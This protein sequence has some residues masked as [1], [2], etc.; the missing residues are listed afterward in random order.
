M[1]FKN[2]EI[3]M[4][5]K[6]SK[7]IKEAIQV[8]EKYMKN[9]AIIDVS[10]T[11]LEFIQELFKINNATFILCSTNRN[12]INAAE[13]R[14]EG[15]KILPRFNKPRSR[16]YEKSIMF[17]FDFTEEELKQNEIKKLY[18][19]SFNFKTYGISLLD[20]CLIKFDYNKGF[21]FKLDEEV[22]LENEKISEL[23]SNLLKS[24]VNDSIGKYGLC[25]EC[26][27]KENCYMDIK[28]S[29]KNA[30][31]P[32]LNESDYLCEFYKQ[33]NVSTPD[34]MMAILYNQ[35]IISN[36]LDELVDYGKINV[37]GMEL[38]VELNI[39]GDK[40]G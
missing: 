5:E 31:T 25:K 11:N 33:F 27:A 16:Y 21:Y 2:I 36:K 9:D 12:I 28:K 38:L 26:V 35:E 39:K 22:L 8:L 23:L 6:D 34:P 4:L 37:A 1:F 32:L 17:P 20:R 30:G 10:H 13:R 7:I 40:N 18:H 19:S 15:I 3:C 24:S 14:I 29:I